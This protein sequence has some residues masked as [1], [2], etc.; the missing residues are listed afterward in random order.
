MLLIRNIYQFTKVSFLVC[1][2]CVVG[3]ES[4]TTVAGVRSLVRVGG[5]VGQH[6]MN[7]QAMIEV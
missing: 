3:A 7:L 6:H 4:H 1:D 5:T 2:E